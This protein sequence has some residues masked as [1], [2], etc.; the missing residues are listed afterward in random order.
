MRVGIL[1]DTHLSGRVDRDLL[2]HVA[3]THFADV[4]AILHA[5]DIGDLTWLSDILFAGIPLYA[6]AGN[7]DPDDGDPRT[8]T[9][10]IV[11]LGS[12]RIG[13]IHGWGS[14][15]GLIDR[16]APLFTDVD[17]VVFG[18]S[19][20]PTSDTR[21][22]IIFFNPGSLTMPRGGPPTAGLLSIDDDD[23]IFQHL[24]F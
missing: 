19:H 13:L 10:R 5:G 20:Q 2:H 11:E 3:A 4:D 16:I 23:L 14:A 6:V 1:S 9:Q 7:C 18:H 22:G 15:Y 8:P 24:A 21:N 17:A 12:R